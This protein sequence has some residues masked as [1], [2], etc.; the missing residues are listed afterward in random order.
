MSYDITNVKS[1]WRT[2]KKNNHRYFVKS[3]RRMV[4]KK[5]SDYKNISNINI[6][7]IKD[8]NMYRYE[9]LYECAKAKNISNYSMMNKKELLEELIKF[10]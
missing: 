4:K 1:H 2:N 8:I 7:D 5:L 3:H 10:K 6:L 9:D